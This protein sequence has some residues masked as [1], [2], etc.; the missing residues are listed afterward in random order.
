MQTS[1]R[2]AIVLVVLV[3]LLICM[4]PAAGAGEGG[5]GSGGAAP[6]HVPDEVLVRFAPGVSPT[7]KSSIHRGLGASTV[8]RYATVTGLELVK[9]PKGA[10]AKEAIKHYRRHL[11]V[12]Y[13]E[14][15]YVVQAVAVL[16]DPLFGS[17]WGLENTGQSRG[18]PGADIDATRAWSLTTGSSNVVVAVIDT[19]IDYTHPDLA[20]NMF[21]NTADCDANGVDDDG[22]GFVDDCHGIDVYHNDSNPMDD[23]SHGTHV[24]GTIGAAGSNGI[25]VVGVNWNV[26]LMPCKFLDA[27]GSGTTAGAI[28]CLNYVAMMKDR[29]VDIVATNHSW[30]GV[31]FSQALYDAIDGHRKRGILFVAAAGN[32]ATDNN[33]APFYPAGYYL[34]NVIS[35]AATTRTD[36]LASFSNFGRQTVHVGAPGSEILS[37]TPANTYSTFSGTSMAA[38]HVTG[39][40]ALLKADDPTRDWRAIRNLILAGGEDSAALTQTISQK[41]LNAYGALTCSGSTVLSRLRPVG[42][43]ITA[44]VGAPVDLAALHVNCADPNGAVT[45][46]VASGARTVATVTLEDDGLA[47]DQ[48]A[49]DGIY[50]GQWTPAAQGTYSLTFP[51]G[52]VVTVAV[53]ANYSYSPTTLVWRTISGSNL[54]LSDDSS[55]A[56]SPPFPIR[57]GGASFATVYVNGNGYLSFTGP[58]NSYVNAAIPTSAIGT[59]VAPFWDDLYPVPGTAQN[60]F[61]AV[62]GAAP[63]RELVIEWRDVRQFG[64]NSDSTATVKF[65]VVFFESSSNILFNYADTVFGGGC[66]FADYGAAATVG[67]QVSPTRGT[68]FSFNAPRLSA[69]TALLWTL[70]PPPPALGVTPVTQDF[71]AVTVGSSVNRSFTVQNTGGGTLTG[72]VSTSAPYSVV[73]G[74]SFSLAPGASQSVVVRFTPSAPGSAPGTVLVSSSAGNVSRAVTGTGVAPTEQITVLSPNGGEVWRI[75]RKYKVTWTAGAVTGKVRIELSRDGG[76]W[77]T[78]FASTPNDRSADWKATGPAA[79]ARIRICDLAGVVCDTSNAPFT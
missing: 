45:V 21:H 38:P 59:L 68:Q 2:G 35:V 3:G 43:S 60:A 8:A 50:S 29:G 72:S 23:N 7:V 47:P 75:N 26:R 79:Q 44:A 9:L 69:S 10:G 40:A 52:D 18:T 17:L 48:A 13:A 32:S 34:P 51:G 27:Q 74:G 61:W 37:T 6:K 46:A 30:G 15:N 63:N 25:G 56:I 64:C 65:Q 66:G 14:P 19:G 4:A 41:R 73:S 22:N 36:A 78:L 71:G 11:D 20:A 62:T 77:Q 33:T 5:E 16:D 58:F 39:L 54:N 67:V 12:L 53:L 31:D 55:A 1:R 70:P 42:S 28:A 24:A 76:P 57:F 49:G